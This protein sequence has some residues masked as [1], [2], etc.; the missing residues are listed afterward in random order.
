FPQQ[1]VS[2]TDLALSGGT[3]YAAL[4]TSDFS[5][6]VAGG[7]SGANGVYHLVN[8]TTADN[9]LNPPMWLIGIPSFTPA[10]D[11]PVIPQADNRLDNFPVPVAPAPKFANFRM[12]VSGSTIL[13]A[14]AY[15]AVTLI[16]GPATESHAFY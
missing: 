11:F 1:D 16:Q 4:G 2:W 15:P 3:L 8:P 9:S 13:A 6:G 10:T 14:I 5:A 12:S 7:G